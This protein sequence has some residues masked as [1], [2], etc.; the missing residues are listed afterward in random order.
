MKNKRFLIFNDSHSICGLEF[1]DAL[2]NQ[3]INIEHLDKKLDKLTYNE[4]NE[5]IAHAVNDKKFFDVIIVY[6]SN[7]Y[8]NDEGLD[9]QTVWHEA[10]NCRI[11]NLLFIIQAANKLIHNRKCK[12]IVLFEKTNTKANKTISSIFTDSLTELIKSSPNEASKNLVSIHMIEFSNSYCDELKGHKNILANRI[13]NSLEFVIG[14][15]NSG[16]IT[17]LG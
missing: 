15:L 11:R 2:S 1:A 16:S 5:S 4:I 10:L 14:N 17:T 7:Y 12:I 6:L 9:Q 13:S 8:L 3:D